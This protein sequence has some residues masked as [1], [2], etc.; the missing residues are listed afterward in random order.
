M[1]SLLVAGFAI[2]DGFAVV[3]GS[4]LVVLVVLAVDVFTLF[5]PLFYFF[6]LFSG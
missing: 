5:L 6:L 1:A 2:V 3:D 4:V